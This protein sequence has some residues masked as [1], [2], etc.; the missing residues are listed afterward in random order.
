MLNMIMQIKTN[1]SIDW[2]TLRKQCPLLTVI[3][4]I[5]HIIH[6]LWKSKPISWKILAA[7]VLR[8]KI[9]VQYYV[10]P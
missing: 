2:K 5:M 4:E 10:S 3:K 6:C 1:I 9:K 8:T 7:A